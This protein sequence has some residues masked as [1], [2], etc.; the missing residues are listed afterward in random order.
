[1]TNSVTGTFGQCESMVKQASHL[2][3]TL[4]ALQATEPQMVAV[5]DVKVHPALQ[6]RAD[7]LV[8]YKDMFRVEERSREQRHALV[9]ALG[10]HDEMNLEPILLARISNEDSDLPSPGLY[11][12]DGHHRLAA[13]RELNRNQIPCRIYP[14]DFPLA[15]L[16]SKPVNCSGRALEMHREQRIDA[17]WQYVSAVTDRGNVRKLPPGESTRTVSRR[18]GVGHNTVARM[19]TQL[20]EIDPEDYS[21]ETLDQGTQWPRWRYVR[22]S[23]SNFPEPSTEERTRRQ[24]EKLARKIVEM[25]SNSTHESRAMALALLAY[26]VSE[27]PDRDEAVAFLSDMARPYGTDPEFALSQWDKGVAELIEAVS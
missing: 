6:P 21:S 14:M 17:A 23:K 22:R 12:V 7:R 8:P 16:A 15:V 10:S 26:E 11:V 20:R 9:L 5:A 13:Y 25:M 18:F 1:M 4:K 2:W 19:L 27:V 3:A 24:A